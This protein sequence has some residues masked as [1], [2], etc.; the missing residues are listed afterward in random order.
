[1]NARRDFRNDEV[2]ILIVE[3]SP[4]QAVQLE[5]ILEQH[6]YRVSVA[7]NGKEALDLVH[8]RKPTMI[9]SDIVMPEMD[10]YQ[11]CQHIK[12]DENLK[13][14][15]VILLT[16]LSDPEDVIRGLECGADNFIT[17]PYDEEL[18]LSRI[19]NLLENRELLGIETS[20]PG[21]EISFKGQSHVITSNR[22]QIFNLLLSTYETAI[23]KNLE[24]IEAR[25]ELQQA[26]EAAEAANRAKSEFLANMSHELRTPLNAIIGFSEVL[27]DQ[28]FGGLNE[29]Q[30]RYINNILTSGR[31]LLQLINDILDLSKIEAGRMEL[32]LTQF[33]VTAA[34]NDIQAIV[35]TLAA[36]KLITLTVDVK[37]DDE[38]PLPTI[39][40][41]QP[42]FKQI[43]Y[44]LLSN[45]IKFTPEGRSVNVTAKLVGGSGE[46]EERE[47]GEPFIQIAVSDTGIGIKREDYE[48]I[49]GEFI[50][51]DSSYARQQQGTGLGLALTRKL[52]EMHGGR[53]WIESEGEGEGSTFTFVLPIIAKK[54]IGY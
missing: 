9:I 29:R 45:A 17:K 32:D 42:K 16:S 40:A 22:P 36:K 10:G 48:R 33:N 37:E 34:L 35:K 39:T 15:P 20:Q 14:I 25:D 7:K 53:I 27:A 21:I 1:M 50:Q 47:V 38:P 46:K 5:Y 28:V 26:K 44:N 52:V 3:D 24:L 8:T 6:D 54:T 4:T 51:L 41:D 2:E 19:Q 31:H 43:M 12:K 18:L 13:D 30:A 23:Q 49:F 11:L